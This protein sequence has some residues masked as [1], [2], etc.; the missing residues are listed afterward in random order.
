MN[1]PDYLTFNYRSTQHIITAA[2]CV[3]S[4]MEDRLKVQHPIVINPERET[5]PDGGI[6]AQIDSE[7][8]GRVRVITLPFFSS[9]S[10]RRNV[11]AQAV[12]AE[13][14]RLRQYGP[15]EWHDIAVLAHDNA[16]LTPL[17]AWCRQESVPYF[18]SREKG[19]RIKLRH[20]REFLRL[21]DAAKQLHGKLLSSKD[22]VKLIHEQAARSGSQWPDWF[23]SLAQDFISEHPEPSGNEVH[24]DEAQHSAASLINWLYEYVGNDSETR[25]EGMFLGTAHSAKGLEFK[26]VFVLDDSW[27]N[28]EDEARRL[29][30]VAMTRAVE[31]L[32]IIQNTPGH[33]WVN[34]LPPDIDRTEWTFDPI[35][36]LNTRYISLSIY[37]DLDLDFIVRKTDEK[38]AMIRLRIAANLKKDD[39]LQIRHL[40]DGRCEFLSNGTPVA[41]TSSKCTS[42]PGNA[43]AHASAFT[44]RYRDDVKEPFTKSI[45]N[46]IGNKILEK[47]PLIVPML[48]IPPGKDH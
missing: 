17:Q 13:L 28:A 39:P 31:T 7:R 36:A 35:P 25:S 10:V 41:R 21:V 48:V 3:I 40:P 11:Q 9:P 23:N 47:W 37:S 2:N 45:P 19:D 8:Q 38:E 20:T 34:H 5:Q 30:Y 6:W 44:V 29:F 1:S 4:G 27:Q 42:I 14:D 22:F 15:I 46:K 12:M 32:T 33:A 24:A 18:C 16:T 43:I 26:H